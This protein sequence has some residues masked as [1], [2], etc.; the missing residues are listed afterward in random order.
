MNPTKSG[1]RIPSSG[2]YQIFHDAHTLPSQVALVKGYNFPPCAECAMPVHFKQVQ[3]MQ[4][5]DNLRGNI[6][7]QALPVL[8]DKAA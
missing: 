3:P 2:L 8:K 4:H 6:V 7:L 1:E 5:L